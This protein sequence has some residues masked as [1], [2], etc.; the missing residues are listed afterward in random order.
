MKT[1]PWLLVP[2]GVIHDGAVVALDDVEGRHATGALRL[3]SGHEVVLADGS[4]RIAAARLDIKGRSRVDAEV[5]SCQVL[6]Q[7]RGEGITLALAV[8]ESKAMDWAVQKAVEIGIRR[9]QP[10]VTDRTQAG[11][12]VNAD[13]SAHWQRVARQALK[14]CRRAW[15]MEIPDVRDLT[16][17]VTSRKGAGVVADPDGVTISSFEL[18][19]RRILVVGP[20]GG[21]SEVELEMFIDRGWTRLRLG[22]HTLRSETAAVVGGALMVACD[23][24]A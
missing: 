17:V 19:Q 24:D 3:R 5:V 23:E 12:R 2:P 11:R 10:I 7:Q 18:P 4:G 1:P 15:E 20:E 22:A 16:A 6:P 21:F 14:Q 8:I 13:R 9:V